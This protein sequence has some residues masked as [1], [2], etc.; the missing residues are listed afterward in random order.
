[1]IERCIELGCNH[2]NGPKG[3][4]AYCFRARLIV[5]EAPGSCSFRLGFGDQLKMSGDWDPRTVFVDSETFRIDC[6]QCPTDLRCHPR[7]LAGIIATLDIIEQEMTGNDF[8]R[9]EKIDISYAELVLS[10][11]GQHDSIIRAPVT[12][13]QITRHRT[14]RLT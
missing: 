9:I 2:R 7:T 12:P 3:L 14:V 8:A 13:R 1:M 5:H 11:W 4:R 6:P 10:W